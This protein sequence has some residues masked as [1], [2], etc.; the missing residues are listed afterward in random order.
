VPELASTGCIRTERALQAPTI[1]VSRASWCFRHSPRRSTSI[2]DLEVRYEA[3]AHN[4]AMAEFC[5][6]DPR[7]IGVAQLSLVDP[8]RAVEEIQEA[9]RLGCGAFWIPAAP[10]GDRSPGHSDFDVVWGSLCDAKRPFML[11]VGP[12]SRLVPPAYFNNGKPLSPDI[13]GGSEN[14][15]VR[16]FA[17]LVRAAVVLTKWCSTAYSSAFEAARRRD[18]ARRRLAPRSCARQ[19]EDLQRTD[20][21]VAALS[22]KAWST[23]GASPLHAVS[24]RRRGRHDPRRRCGVV[25]SR[26]TTRTPKA[27]MIRSAA[28]SARS[29]ASLKAL[30]SSSTAAT[31]STCS[32][33]SGLAHALVSLTRRT[34]NPLHSEAARAQVQPRQHAEAVRV[35]RLNDRPSPAIAI[36]LTRNWKPA[37]PTGCER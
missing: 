4:R 8:T 18:R 2:T 22:A 6:S 16:D 36:A 20:P 13:V 15:R 31:S 27:P 9:V 37:P 34:N 21:H 33:G 30:S 23:S 35:I 28:S 19:A 7:L 14:L 5:K 17:T 3:S 32:A 12:N 29:R 24:G 10:V 11:H 1:W 26:A 25:F